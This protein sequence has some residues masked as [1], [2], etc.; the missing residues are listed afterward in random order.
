MKNTKKY[1]AIKG[2][3]RGW[4]SSHSKTAKDQK[5]T[6]FLCSLWR[7]DQICS[8]FQLVFLFSTMK[9]NDV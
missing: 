1:K 7:G 8:P 2:R 9:T 4:Q 3:E 6:P 5:V